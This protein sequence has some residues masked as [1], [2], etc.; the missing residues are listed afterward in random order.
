MPNAKK[1]EW[2]VKVHRHSFSKSALDGCE[3]S[4]RFGPFTLHYNS[5][6]HRTEG[7]MLHRTCLEVLKKIKLLASTAFE[8]RT[9]Q[10]VNWGILEDKANSN[11]SPQHESSQ[12]SE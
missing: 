11:H 8:P 5:G 6:T 10:P 4:S 7:W 9:F 12:G 3:L 1:V 2:G